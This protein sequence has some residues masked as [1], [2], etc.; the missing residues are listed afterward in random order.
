MSDSYL[1]TEYGGENGLY[2]HM[3]PGLDSRLDLVTY[4]SEVRLLYL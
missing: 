3:D 4:H 2:N 1:A